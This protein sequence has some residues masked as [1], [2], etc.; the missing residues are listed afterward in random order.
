MP[1]F[2]L[3]RTWLTMWLWFINCNVLGNLKSYRFQGVTSAIYIA[4]VLLA[5]SEV[6]PITGAP[7]S[8]RRF[9]TKVTSLLADDMIYILLLQ[10][11]FALQR[12]KGC[13]NEHT[14]SSSQ[15][16]WIW[17]SSLV[18]FCVPMKVHRG[19]GVEKPSFKSTAKIAKNSVDCTKMWFARVTYKLTD[20]L[21]CMRD[22]KT[23]HG[24]IY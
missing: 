5:L 18:L 13:P 12:N 3:C 19:I 1:Y 8:R 23:S 21:Y 24:K 4:L 6:K 15:T 7:S 10:R 17:T 22:I 16:L 9:R 14:P 20:S 11:I 2:L